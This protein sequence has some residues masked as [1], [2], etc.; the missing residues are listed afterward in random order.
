AVMVPFIAIQCP[1]KVQ[2]KVYSPGSFKLNLIVSDSPGPS[3]LV[4]ATISVKY[5]SEIK[6]VSFALAEALANCAT[7]VFFSKTTTL[8]PM[9]SIGKT[10]ALVKFKV[11]SS[12][13]LTVNSVLSNFIS[14]V[15][16]MEISF[17]IK[18]SWDSV[19]CGVSV[20]SFL[21]EEQEINPNPKMNINIKFFI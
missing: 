14:S 9:V 7:S 16:L 13:A 10:P 15:A 8:C 2:M 3:N 11:I 20:V 5:N 6:S 1:G 19:V 4:C 21:S 12:S 17:E 18:Y